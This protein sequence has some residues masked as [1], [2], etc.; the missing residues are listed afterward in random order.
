MPP[1]LRVVTYNMLA[2]VYASTPFAKHELFPTCSKKVL[3]VERRWPMII[4]EV[5]EYKPDLVALQEVDSVLHERGVAL[6]MKHHGGASHRTVVY[7]FLQEFLQEF[8]GISVCWQGACQG[9]V[10]RNTARWSFLL[11]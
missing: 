7:V 1:R 9:E 10:L 2:D 5:L 11:P 6:P 4:K 8:V 3:A